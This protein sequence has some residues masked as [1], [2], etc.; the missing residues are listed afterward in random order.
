ML[1]HVPRIT[2]R[3]IYT[4]DLVLKQLL[5]LDFSLTSNTE[6]FGIY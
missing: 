2:D 4:F 1:V 5:G 6:E 3:V